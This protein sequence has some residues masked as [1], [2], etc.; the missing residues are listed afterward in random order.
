MLLHYQ[1]THD[2]KVIRHKFA[3]NEDRQT[4]VGKYQCIVA[5]MV[6]INET[7]KNAEDEKSKSWDEQSIIKKLNTAIELHDDLIDSY[8][9]NC[10]PDKFIHGMRYAQIALAGTLFKRLKTMATSDIVEW[11]LYKQDC[12][13][14]EHESLDLIDAA[15]AKKIGTKKPPSKSIE[16]REKK[17]HNKRKKYSSSSSNS[18]S[19]SSS[20]SNSSSSSSSSSR[21]KSNKKRSK[22]SSSNKKAKKEEKGNETKIKEEKVN[23]TKNKKE[24]DN[25]AKPSSA[26]KTSS[27]KKTK[28]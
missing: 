15:K 10:L 20:S 21:K 24:E 1:P 16:T 9:A 5:L 18:S 6:Q 13:D 12:D 7:I 27:R 19:G 23:E 3:S 28:K 14:I 4:Y 22:R 26:T 25:K 17:K 11:K 8:G 2:N